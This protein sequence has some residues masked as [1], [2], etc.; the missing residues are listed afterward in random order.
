MEV[1]IRYLELE[2]EVRNRRLCHH[3][4]RCEG[5]GSLLED[6]QIDNLLEEDAT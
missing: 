1:H 5:E 6:H 4:C 2:E 3:R